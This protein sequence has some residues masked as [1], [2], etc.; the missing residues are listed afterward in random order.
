MFKYQWFLWYIT[1]N[2]Y[3]VTHS[4]LVQERVN[5]VQWGQSCIACQSTCKVRNYVHNY[6]CA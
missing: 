2:K 1:K 4:T 5:Y 6:A 3:Y